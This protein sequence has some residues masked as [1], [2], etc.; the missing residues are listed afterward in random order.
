MIKL[1]A[2]MAVVYAFIFAGVYLLNNDIDAALSCL[3]GAGI[4]FLNLVGFFIAMKLVFAKK[5][6][7]LTVSVIIFKYTILSLVFWK[8]TQVSW[9]K[10][11]GFVAGIATLVLAILSMTAV[12][13]FAKKL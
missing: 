12:K 10:P 8:L 6:I 13:S 4:M 3:V 7:A 1:T 2:T 11:V 9:L 5:S